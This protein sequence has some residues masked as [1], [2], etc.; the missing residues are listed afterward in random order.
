MTATL[1]K[2][3]HGAH[4]VVSIGLQCEIND[5]VFILMVAVNNQTW[6]ALINGGVHTAHYTFLFNHVNHNTNHCSTH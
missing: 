5:V 6:A 4:S 2:Y 3:T 1:A